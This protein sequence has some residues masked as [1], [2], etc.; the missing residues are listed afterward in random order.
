MTDP[1]LQIQV[2]FSAK[3]VIFS[4]ISVTT[5]SENAKP[6]PNVSYF[7]DE[8]LKNDSVQYLVNASPSDLHI[9]LSLLKTILELPIGNSF[10]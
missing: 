8:E 3:Y 9:H 2:K 4:A 7:I 5:W 1:G 6:Q 10:N